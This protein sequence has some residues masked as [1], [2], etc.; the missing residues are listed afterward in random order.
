MRPTARKPTISNS[1]FLPAMTQRPQKSDNMIYGRRRY[2][3]KTS[4]LYALPNCCASCKQLFKNA[5]STVERRLS[6]KRCVL[7]SLF[8]KGNVR[9]NQQLDPGLYDARQDLSINTNSKFH[10]A[11]LQMFCL[12]VCLLR[13][14]KQQNK[15]LT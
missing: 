15:N 14:E 4:Q 9:G 6:Q 11:A 1:L 7:L 2:Y 8:S 3:V 10:P 12:F 13:D 5:K